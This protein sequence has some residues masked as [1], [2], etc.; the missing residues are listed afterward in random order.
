MSALLEEYGLSYQH[1]SK[2]GRVDGKAL[3]CID[4]DEVKISMVRDHGVIQC[5]AA[6]GLIDYLG[7]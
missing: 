6:V 3:A 1:D 5:A 4:R 7:F 2:L